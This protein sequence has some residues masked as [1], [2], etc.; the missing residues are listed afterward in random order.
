MFIRTQQI[1]VATACM[2]AAVVMAQSEADKLAEVIKLEADNNPDGS[3]AFAYETSNGIAAQESGIGGEQA[4]GGF[5]WISPE[6]QTID[7]QYTAGPNGY[8]PTGDAIPVAPEVPAHVARL[9]EYLAAHPNND[10]G[11][12]KP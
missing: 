5:K 4:T 11:S 12:Y 7:I 1:L 2:V 3:Y 8:V 9:V 6:G 10:D